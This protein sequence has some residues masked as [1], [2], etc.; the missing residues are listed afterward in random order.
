[1]NDANVFEDNLNALIRLQRT[2]YL[3]DGFPTPQTRVERLER[4][5]ALLVENGDQIAS[6]LSRDFG[7]RSHDETRFEILGAVNALR[8]AATKVENWLKP[9]QCAPMAPDA[10]ARV[11]Y[12]P[13]GVVGVIGPWNFPIVCVFG[14]LAGI[15]AAGNRAVVKPSEFTPAT[16]K[17]LAQLIGDKFA[18]GEVSMVQG[19]AKEGATFA[20]AP[21]D[22]LVFRFSLRGETCDACCRHQSDAGYARARG[23]VAGHR[24]RAVRSCRSGR[25]GNDG[26]DPQRR[27]DLPR[28]GLCARPG[29]SRTRFRRRMRRR[30]Q[31]DV[32][33]R[34]RRWRLH[35]DYLRPASPA[36]RNA[37]RRRARCSTAPLQVVSPS[38]MS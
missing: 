31:A 14:P 36:P 25:A 27:P 4:M 1:M 22:H 8:T 5:A 13:L 32:S 15:L 10:E 35:V 2:A 21:F 12:M 3:R 9:V 19:A 26:E 38:M 34:G 28:A 18:P 7:H 6:A 29:G 37:G 24:H 20:A 30:R 16:S 11:E 17:L 33:R 23:K